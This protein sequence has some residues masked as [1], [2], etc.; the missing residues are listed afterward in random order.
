MAAAQ[1]KNSKIQIKTI[2]KTNPN[3]RREETTATTPTKPIATK[4]F[5]AKNGANRFFISIH[6]QIGG[7]L[8]LYSHPMKLVCP[9]ESESVSIRQAQKLL[10]TSYFAKS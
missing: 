8:S 1:I 2:H 3:L 9:F 5:I 4:K 10:Q 6:S 7:F